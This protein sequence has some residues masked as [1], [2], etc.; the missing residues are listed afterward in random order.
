MV[1]TASMSSIRHCSLNSELMNS[2]FTFK[3]I[4]ECIHNDSWSKTYLCSACASA[5]DENVAPK[6]LL[7]TPGDCARAASRRVVLV[8]DS[9][10]AQ[11][12]VLA[13]C[14][15][16]SLELRLFMMPVVPPVPSLRLILQQALDADLVIFSFGVWYNWDPHESAP[17]A[18]HSGQELSVQ[19]VERCVRFGVLPPANRTRARFALEGACASVECMLAP[20]PSA[21]M[22]YAFRRRLCPGATDRAA[23]TSDLR[24]FRTTLESILSE[25]RGDPSDAP[26]PS[27]RATRLIWRST[28]IQHYETP[29]GLFPVQRSATWPWGG[30]RQ[31]CVPIKPTER[32][33]SRGRA[34]DAQHVLGPLTKA[35]RRLTNSTISFALHDTWERDRDLHAHSQHPGSDGVTF[36]PGRP[37][38]LD[39]TH[40]CLHSDVAIGWL[41]AL[42]GVALAV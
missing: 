13:R 28:S 22:A 18:T 11:L 27:I 39:C 6:E 16:P 34:T 25:T 32:A 17:R 8:G 36:A 15:L 10:I 1:D 26:R 4:D 30:A 3:H 23:Y 24:R 37:H 29:G 20:P 35:V 41:R 38:A 7:R 5:C 42:A 9:L 40:F 14:I 12:Y 33:I 31:R 2:A 21:L 19:I